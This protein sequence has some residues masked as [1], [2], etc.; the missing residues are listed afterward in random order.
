MTPEQFANNVSTKIITGYQDEPVDKEAWL[1]AGRS[2]RS[3][4]MK[5]I[6]MLLVCFVAI[7]LTG[8]IETSFQIQTEKLDNG[9]T[10]MLNEQGYP[11]FKSYGTNEY[12]A[13]KTA[14][15][16]W[17]ERKNIRNGIVTPKVLEKQE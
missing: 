4:R 14:I 9:Y 3:N 1:R 5:N 2:M 13:V 17:M 7:F 11:I 15:D 6:Y 10:A 16:S 8:C 12:D